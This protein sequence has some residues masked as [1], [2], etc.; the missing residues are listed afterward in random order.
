LAEFRAASL[1]EQR[2]KQTRARFDS[3]PGDEQQRWNSVSF[4]SLRRRFI[5]GS[6]A[7]LIRD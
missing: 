4:L 1:V 7:L 3:K 5:S 6:E 2:E